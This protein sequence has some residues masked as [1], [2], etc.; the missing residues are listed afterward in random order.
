MSVYIKDNYSDAFTIQRSH[1]T[2]WSDQ[3]FEQLNFVYITDITAIA[4]HESAKRLPFI[5]KYTLQI[6]AFTD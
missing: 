5:T 4:G 2:S 1:L 6:H 3:L